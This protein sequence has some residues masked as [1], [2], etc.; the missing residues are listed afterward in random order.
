MAT[1]C[2]RIIEIHIYVAAFTLFECLVCF[3]KTTLVGNT[4]TKPKI[5]CKFVYLWNIANCGK[6]WKWTIRSVHS[7]A[8]TPSTLSLAYRDGDLESHH[9]LTF[10]R[11]ILF[12]GYMLVIDETNFYSLWGRNSRLRHRNL[13]SPL[14]RLWKVRRPLLILWGSKVML[15]LM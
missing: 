5:V 7:N 1:L 2:T 3:L 6:L 14:L 12:R 8:K 9:W 11:L 15:I 13:L 10:Q 4:H